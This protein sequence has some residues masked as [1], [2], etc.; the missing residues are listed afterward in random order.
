MSKPTEGMVIESTPPADLGDVWLYRAC[1]VLEAWDSKSREL[2][3]GSENAFV[4]ARFDLV[5]AHALTSTVDHEYGEDEW[6]LNNGKEG[7]ERVTYWS[8]GAVA[9]EADFQGAFFAFSTLLDA[10][11]RAVDD[12]SRE[13]VDRLVHTRFELVEQYGMTVEFTGMPVSGKKH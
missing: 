8:P 3:T 13:E 2:I 5:Q 12:G 1:Q 7:H 6:S 9:E 11:E 10:I 4:A